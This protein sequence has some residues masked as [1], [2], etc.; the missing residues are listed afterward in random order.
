MDFPLLADL[1]DVERREV[2]MSARRRRYRAGDTIFHE[3]DP[4]DSFHLITK[5]RVL[6]RS[7]APS[8]EVVSLAVLSPGEGFG[9]QI[10]LNDDALRTASAQA[11]GPVETLSLNHHVFAELCARYPKVQWVLMRQLA[12]QVRRLS[13][14]VVEILYLPAETRVL[15]QLLLLDRVHSGQI[16]HI[17]QEEIASLAGTTR[18]TVNR[19]MRAAATAGALGLARAQFRVL[20]RAVLERL[21]R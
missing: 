14:Q 10:L 6:I 19:V 9:E 7:S 8:G 17:T 20:D 12:A 16:V 4:G 21:A 5:G 13:R 11:L 15:R 2:L 3:G 18:P 1:S